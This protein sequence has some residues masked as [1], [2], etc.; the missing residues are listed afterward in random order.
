MFI[1]Q[2]LSDA[3][4]CP[5][6]DRSAEQRPDVGI[7]RHDGV[8]IADTLA[9]TLDFLGTRQCL[10]NARRIGAVDSGTLPG[11]ENDLVIRS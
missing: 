5:D 2:H 3:D 8:Q 9:N 11:A 10:V 1:L 6:G 4:A 7:L